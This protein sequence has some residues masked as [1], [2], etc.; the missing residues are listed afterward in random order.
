MM[1]T[2]FFHCLFLTFWYSVVYI[3]KH[4]YWK[5][6][7]Q[8]VFKNQI[9]PFSIPFIWARNRILPSLQNPFICPLFVTTYIPTHPREPPTSNRIDLFLS[10]FVFYVKGNIYSIV[11]ISGCLFGRV[12]YIV[13]VV[14]VHS[15]CGMVICY[16][17]V[18]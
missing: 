12:I 17:N 2:I 11:S 4:S 8:W 6:L 16:V 18:A 13:G 14:V 7:A 9:H 5:Y 3:Q 15:Y 1:I 10:V